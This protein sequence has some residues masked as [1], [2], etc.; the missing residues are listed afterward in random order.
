MTN[1]KKEREAKLLREKVAH[2]E[3]TIAILEKCQVTFLKV[4]WEEL[5]P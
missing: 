3:I 4:T 5:G 2:W 1:A